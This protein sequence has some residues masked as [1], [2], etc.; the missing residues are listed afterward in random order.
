MNV[1][2]GRSALGALVIAVAI[3]S[4][5]AG[6]AAPQQPSSSS[7]RTA[8]SAGAGDD[9]SSS[10]DPCAMRLHEV[11]GV[12]LLYYNT[13]HDLPPTLAALAQAPGAKDAGDLAC[14]ASVQP[15]VY[16]PAGVPVDP[17]PSRVVLFDPTPAHGGP[18][19]G[20]RFAIV[21][22]PP[23][24]PGGVLQARVIAIPEAKAKVL[25][26]AVTAPAAAMSPT[27]TTRP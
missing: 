18:G 3:L 4:I 12:L 22:Q 6:C 15:Y 27:S 7:S 11:C 1:Y 9:A 19:G 23:S 5:A 25:R 24:Q 20:K 10:T 8:A 26:D 17:P 21:I 13:H 16:I 14:P 2:A